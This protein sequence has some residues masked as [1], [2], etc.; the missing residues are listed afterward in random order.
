VAR[1]EGY[2]AGCSLEFPQRINVLAGLEFDP[3]L[4]GC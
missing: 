1:E 2:K 3:A 4:S